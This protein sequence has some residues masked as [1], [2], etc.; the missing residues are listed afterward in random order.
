MSKKKDG[1]ANY[2]F[3]VQR[4]PAKRMGSGDFANMPPNMIL[5]PFSPNQEYQDGSIQSFVSTIKD[6]TGIS[7]NQR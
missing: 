2:N 6:N 1:G 3:L 4:Q 7:E 5:Q